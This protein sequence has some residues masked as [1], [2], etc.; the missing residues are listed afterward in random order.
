[1]IF[2]DAYVYGI[3]MM[4]IVSVGLFYLEKDVTK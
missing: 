4:A 1:M 3:I 2:I